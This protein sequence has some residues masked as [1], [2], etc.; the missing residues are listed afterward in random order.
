[1]I[2]ECCCGDCVEDQIRRHRPALLE[3][4]RAPVKSHPAR[5]DTSKRDMPHR[6]AA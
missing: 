1:M 5:Y 2:P 6:R 3:P 4:P